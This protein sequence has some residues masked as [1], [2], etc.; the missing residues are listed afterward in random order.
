MRRLSLSEC[1]KQLM[2]WDQLDFKDNTP[3][4]VPPWGMHSFVLPF[5]FYS[6]PL[7]LINLFIC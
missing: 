4:V 1:P 6:Y 3:T 7:F 2:V 5:Y